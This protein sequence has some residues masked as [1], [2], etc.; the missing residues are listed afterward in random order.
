MIL[1][2]FSSGCGRLDS[3]LAERRGTAPESLGRSPEFAGGSARE[4]ARGRKRAGVGDLVEVA[5][6]AAPLVDQAAG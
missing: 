1:Q 4:E 6:G 3:L 5:A 2:F